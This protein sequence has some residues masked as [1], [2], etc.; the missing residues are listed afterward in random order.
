MAR[1]DAVITSAAMEEAA[2][3]AWGEHSVYPQQLQPWRESAMQ[4]VAEPEEAPASPQ[5]TKHDRR[6]MKELEHEVRRKDGALAEAAA[7]LALTKKS[8]RSSTR[9]T[10]RTNDR[11]RRSPGL[12]QTS[13]RATRVGARLHPACETAGI[14]VRMPARTR[15]PEL[16]A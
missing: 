2:K 6:H 16:A 1:L 14:D 8:R 7:L 5:Q 3:S 13:K 12:A 4:P 10:A 9:T 15:M 11:P